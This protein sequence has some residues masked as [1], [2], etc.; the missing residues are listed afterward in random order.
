M[1]RK[2]LIGLALLIVVFLVVAAFQPSDFRVARS[3]SIAAPPAA[4]F[5]RVN[6]FHQWVAWSPWEKLDPEM[7]RT[8]EGP[9]AGSGASYGW[10][11]NNKV[12]EGRATIVES[13]PNELIRIKLDFVKPFASTSLAEYTFRAEGNQTTVTWSM[14]GEKNFATK[15]I[16]LIVSMDKMVGG[17][18][19][20]GLADLKKVSEAGAKK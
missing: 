12:G 5:P 17:D 14:A 10:V 4:I 15:A 7:K 3:I 19:E 13:R 8:Y 20:K 18:F 9:S 6:D 16:C 2:I 11:G 1:I